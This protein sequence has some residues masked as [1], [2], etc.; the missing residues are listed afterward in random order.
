[1]SDKQA[2]IE[3]KDQAQ[4]LCYVIEALPASVARTDLSI[5]ASELLKNVKDFKL[6]EPERWWYN[7]GMQKIHAN[8]IRVFKGDIEIPAES[9]EYVK[10]CIELHK[11]GKVNLDKFKLRKLV[12]GENVTWLDAFYNLYTDVVVGC[13]GDLCFV[14]KPAF[15]IPHNGINA[16]KFGLELKPAKEPMF[17]EYPITLNPNMTLGY[18]VEITHLFKQSRVEV[19]LHKLP[20]IVGFAGVKF[21]EKKGEWSMPVTGFQKHDGIPLTPIAA[22]FYIKESR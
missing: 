19:P 7:S 13:A 1:M 9:V 18:R 3:A 16:P 5:Q 17:V 4:K 2:M 14:R 20:S 11:A 22:R 8:S 10:K 6:P 15:D 21:A 12:K